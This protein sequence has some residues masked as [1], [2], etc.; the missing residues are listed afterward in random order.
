MI[1]LKMNSDKIKKLL[2]SVQHGVASALR[3]VRVTDQ[4]VCVQ[5]TKRRMT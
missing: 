4:C 1:V 2:L 5:L 3:D